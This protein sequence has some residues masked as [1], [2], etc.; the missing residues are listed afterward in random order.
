VKYKR[1]INKQGYNT[2]AS[3][4]R[5]TSTTTESHYRPKKNVTVIMNKPI[6]L[7]DTDE[8]NDVD[9]RPVKMKLNGFIVPSIITKRGS[10]NVTY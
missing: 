1:N 6:E 2:F 10:I 4:I 9:M 3:F 8:D 7:D 5:T